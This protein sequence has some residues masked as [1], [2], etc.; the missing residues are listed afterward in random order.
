MLPQH[1][2]AD[3]VHDERLMATPLRA[4]REVFLLIQPHLKS[5]PATRLVVDWIVGQFSG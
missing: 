2:S 1:L 5:D 4:R 3:L